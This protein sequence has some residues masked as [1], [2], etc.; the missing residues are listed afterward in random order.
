ML[1]I[2]NTIPRS[3]FQC[4]TELGQMFQRV[5]AQ[6]HG[7]TRSTTS[8]LSAQYTFRKGCPFKTLLPSFTFTASKEL[9]QALK[10]GTSQCHKDIESL[11][12]I[13]HFLKSQITKKTYLQYLHCMHCIYTT[14]ESLTIHRVPSSIYIPWQLHRR[15][16]LEHDLAF[17]LGEH[18]KDAIVLSAQTKHYSN[19]LLDLY[20]KQ[21]MLLVAHAYTRYM[22]DLSGG[23]ILQKRVKCVLE[24]DD[25]NSDEGLTFYTFNHITNISEWK[26]SYRRELDSWGYLLEEGMVEKLV[27]EANVAFQWN[28][29]ILGEL[30]QD[31]N[32]TEMDIN[33]HGLWSWILASVVGLAVAVMVGWFLNNPNIS[34]D[35]T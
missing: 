14:L 20:Q 26:S 11:P 2:W 13:Q 31:G 23:K 8:G 16:S 17:H 1:Q 34:H 24:S 19:Y 25:C 12:F 29:N 30:E 22:G 10:S 9:S 7:V 28:G 33:S 3:H 18:W 32:D 15:K 27:D 5:I 4:T 6:L 35:M 21:P